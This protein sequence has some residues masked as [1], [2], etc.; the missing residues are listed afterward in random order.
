MYPF[1][2]AF[3]NPQ[4]TPIRALFK[5]MS[6]PEM[7]SFA[8]GYPDPQL[9]DTEGLQEAAARAWA[10]SNE[11]LQYA[12]TDGIPKIKAQ[13]IALMAAQ[14]ITAEPA[15]ITV[16]T[17]SQQAFDLL[18]DVFID[19]GDVVYLESPTFPSNIMAPRVHGAQL[20]PLP[21]DADGMDVAQLEAMLHEA[22]AQGQALPKLIYTI[23]T[24]AN[25]AGSTMPRERRRRLLELAVEY[26][27]VIAEDDPYSELRFAGEPVL[28]LAALAKEV[29]GASDQVV[30][31]STL[32]KTVAPGLRIGWS[33]APA[34]IARRCSVAKQTADS[35]SSAWTQSI[36]AEY[37]ASGRLAERIGVIQRAYGE[38]CQ[39]L[40]T[41]LREKLGT[42]IAFHEPQGGMF[43]WG[44]LIDGTSASEYIKE[45]VARKVMFVP[46]G[47]FYVDEDADHATLRISFATP[48]VANIR[49][50]VARMAQAWETLV[51]TRAPARAVA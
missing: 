51:S 10:N 38:K 1:A 25:P 37:L 18:L 7:I 22:R 26:R 11:C 20:R 34:E 6:D 17:G 4:I 9:F 21:M 29:P 14:S 42:A 5:Y 43:V 44:R 15:N 39:A 13:I 24:F 36:A 50:G 49:E 28:S 33:V 2:R 8:G 16:T 35:N 3:A 27:F 48:S 40:C 12:N 45:A 30:Y 32:S 23:P 46:G 31:M 47:G 19:T 41:A